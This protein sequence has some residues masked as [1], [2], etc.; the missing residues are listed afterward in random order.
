MG[1][2]GAATIHAEAAERH[3]KA[4]NEWYEIRSLKAIIESA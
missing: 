4:S 2:I 3:I 1:H